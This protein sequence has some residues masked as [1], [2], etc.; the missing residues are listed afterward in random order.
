[1]VDLVI[2][3]IST[4]SANSPDKPR[5]Q[6]QLPKVKQHWHHKQQNQIERFKID[7]C[8]NIPNSFCEPILAVEIPDPQSSHAGTAD[9]GQSAEKGV[10]RFRFAVTFCPGLLTTILSGLCHKHANDAREQQPKLETS[11]ACVCCWQETYS[12]KINACR[13]VVSDC[14]RCSQTFV[15]NK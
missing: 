6:E 9:Q 11:L 12:G 5:V 15:C 10:L 7:R 4:K 13:H 8:L 1:M 14:R 3:E 2:A